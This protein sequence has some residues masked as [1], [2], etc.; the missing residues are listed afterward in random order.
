VAPHA[1]YFGGFEQQRRHDGAAA[2]P[3]ESHHQPDAAAGKREQAKI[4]YGQ[5]AD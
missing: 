2:D 4:E 1:Q 5:F 3:G